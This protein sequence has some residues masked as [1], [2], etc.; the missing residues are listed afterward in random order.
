[1][2]YIIVTNPFW[3]NYASDAK[4]KA[5]ELLCN[6]KRYKLIFMRG[7]ATSRGAQGLFLTLCSGVTASCAKK[8]YVVG[9]VV[10]GGTYVVV[11]VFGHI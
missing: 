8:P 2:K 1:M 7:W 4:I 11:F 3:Y 9:V 5:L 10:F 6:V